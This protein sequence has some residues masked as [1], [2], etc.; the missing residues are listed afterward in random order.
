MTWY[1]LRTNYNSSWNK[2]GPTASLIIIPDF[3]RS[4]YGSSCNFLF[5]GLILIPL[6]S[7]SIYFHGMPR[8]SRRCRKK[9]ENEAKKWELHELL[10]PEMVKSGT[11]TLAS[12]CRV[13]AI[14]PLPDCLL[15][16]MLCF[17]AELFSESTHSVGCPPPGGKLSCGG[18]GHRE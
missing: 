14:A 2:M 15:W 7:L 12:G 5:F 6:P 10:Y 4:V 17:H 18:G 13:L 3:A 16:R 9:K 11:I 8:Y 1:L